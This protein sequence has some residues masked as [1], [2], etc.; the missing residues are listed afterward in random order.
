MNDG[1]RHTREI[2]NNT[3]ERQ[4]WCRT[5]KT[6]GFIV[7]YAMLLLSV[8]ILLSYVLLEKSI[9]LHKIINDTHEYQRAFTV[10]LSVLNH[11]TVE[12]AEAFQYS[13]EVMRY[14]QYDCVLYAWQRVSVYE[15]QLL[16]ITMG[17]IEA[18]YITEACKSDI[19]PGRQG[20]WLQ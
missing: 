1:V 5:P 18:S 11:E 12:N 8:T 17:S 7:C 19:I 9:M 3:K 15:N 20:Y 10:G 16:W 6:S 13:L 14:E 2:V 4:A